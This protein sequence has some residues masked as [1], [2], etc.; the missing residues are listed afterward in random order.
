MSEADYKK[1]VRKNWAGWL[2]SYEPRRGSGIGMADIQIVSSG[3]LIPIELKIGFITDGKLSVSEIRAA[4]INWHRELNKAGVKSF[5]MIGVKE[6]KGWRSFVVDAAH[7]RNMDNT[8]S[9]W[10]VDERLIEVEISDKASAA[11]NLNLWLIANAKP[12]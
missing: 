5:F 3:R 2:E 11:K 7:I 9:L 10:L 6:P 4:Q 8:P 12:N 1:F